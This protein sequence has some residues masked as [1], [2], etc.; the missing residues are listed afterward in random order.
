MSTHTIH[1]DEILAPDEEAKMLREYSSGVSMT[2]L[3][4]RYGMSAT[5][6]KRSIKSA[7]QAIRGRDEAST[8]R[9][10]R[11][12]EDV[13]AEQRSSENELY[14]EN[15]LGIGNIANEMGWGRA[16]ERLVKRILEAE[17]VA[18]RDRG[19]SLKAVWGRQKAGK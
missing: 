18:L 11:R 2:E 16:G 7:G 10:N 13:S 15:Q 3:A 14:V 8:L 17:G 1:E 6:I 9:K 19:E 4:R 12:L 5:S